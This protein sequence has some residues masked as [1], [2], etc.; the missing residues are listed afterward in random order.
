MS[1]SAKERKKFLSNDFIERMIRVEQ[2][3]STSLG[4]PVSYHKTMYYRGLT[5]AEKRSFDLYLKRKGMKKVL[6]L[7]PVFLLLLVFGL[8]NFEFTGNVVRENAHSSGWSFILFPLLVF[9]IW[10]Y[11]FAFLMGKIRAARFEA[12]FG[13]IDEIGTNRYKA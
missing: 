10:A 13:V 11:V 9:L 8:V 5:D 6:V 3:V 4:Q 1:P 7:L 2:R 12:H